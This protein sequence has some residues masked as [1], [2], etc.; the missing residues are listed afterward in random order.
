MREWQAESIRKLVVESNVSLVLMIIEESKKYRTSKGLYAFSNLKLPFIICRSMRRIYLS[1]LLKTFSVSCQNLLKTEILDE[2]GKLEIDILKKYD[3]DFFLN[4]GSDSLGH[5]S[6]RAANNGTLLFF[7]GDETQG[8]SEPLCFWEIYAGEP[9]IG[10]SLLLSHGDIN[11]E[12]VLQKGFFRILNH[13]LAASRDHVLMSAAEWPARLCRKIQSGSTAWNA[14]PCEIIS[15]SRKPKPSLVGRTLFF[16]KLLKNLSLRFRRE[17]I[18]EKW[19]FGIL[20]KPVYSLLEDTSLK[21]IR[22]YPNRSRWHSF[23]DP[24]C[25]RQGP[26]THIFVEQYDY[27][28]GRGCIAVINHSSNRYFGE[29]KV[30]IEMPFH[31]SYPYL[32]EYD[33]KIYCVPEISQSRQVCLFR[34]E[35]FPDH[36]VKHKVLIHDFAAE[37]STIFFHNRRWYLLCCNLEDQDQTKLYGWTA[38]DLF[39]PWQPHPL[40]PLKCDPR[41]SRPAGPPFEHNGSLFRP[42]QDCSDTYGGAVTITQIKVLSPKEFKEEMIARIEPDPNGPYP[43]GLHTICAAGDITI[44]DGKRHFCTAITIATSITR[45]L[46]IKGLLSLIKP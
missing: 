21:G 27:R 29:P 5:D 11:R 9:I 12:T 24:F 44:I 4:F 26:L 43:D 36:W 34:A 39:G 14:S 6:A 38:Q 31:M 19:S 13:N 33:S 23:A 2:Q 30:V 8:R 32:L 40:N 46:H 35:S 17:F 10:A 15:S 45:R 18:E 20:D 1:S 42:T 16:F 25:F 7:F 41:S 22:W 28:T 3:I 37:D